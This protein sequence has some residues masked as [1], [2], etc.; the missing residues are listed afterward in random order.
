MSSISHIIKAWEQSFQKAASETNRLRIKATMQKNREEQA[1]KKFEKW[2]LDNEEKFD[3]MSA[4]DIAK[5]AHMVGF[6]RGYNYYRENPHNVIDIKPIDKK[7]LLECFK[8]EKDYYELH[9]SCSDTWM[10]FVERSI[11]QLEN[12]GTQL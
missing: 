4:Y 6:S 5:N 9:E 8:R 7:D 1:Q 3:G 12:K 2:F 11:R 10:K